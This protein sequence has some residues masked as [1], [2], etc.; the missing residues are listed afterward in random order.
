MRIKSLNEIA[1]GTQ[2]VKVLTE[3]RCGGKKVKK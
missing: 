1:I 3:R 2:I